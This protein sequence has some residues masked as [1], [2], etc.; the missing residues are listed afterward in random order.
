MVVQDLTPVQIDEIRACCDQVCRQLGVDES[1]TRSVLANPYEAMCHCGFPCTYGPEDAAVFNAVILAAVPVDVPLAASEERDL[2]GGGPDSWACFACFWGIT[3]VATV[4]VTAA[5]I[6]LAGTGWGFV[7]AV[8]IRAVAGFLSVSIAMVTGVASAIGAVSVASGITLLATKL[9][10]TFPD[11]CSVPEPYNGVWSV[12]GKPDEPVLSQKSSAAPALTSFRG[13]PLLAHK[14]HG[15]DRR[16]WIGGVFGR[17]RW[18]AA[19]CP[20]IR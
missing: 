7:A 2:V 20:S 3:A 14:G 9:C 13:Q 10:E 15:G 4:A 12:D 18:L 17:R 19:R 5:G 16:L 11:T 8:V 6:A 1:Y